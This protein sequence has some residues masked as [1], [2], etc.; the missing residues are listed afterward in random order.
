MCYPT[1]IDYLYIYAGPTAHLQVRLGQHTAA[2]LHSC[3]P[4]PSLYALARALQAVLDLDIYGLLFQVRPIL[5]R[6]THNST[7]A[8]K[9]YFIATADYSPHTSLPQP[10]S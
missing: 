4:D 2:R 1:A 7:T 9:L 6:K 5:Q 10:T 3:A 8:S